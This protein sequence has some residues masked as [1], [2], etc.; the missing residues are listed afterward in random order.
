MPADFDTLVGHGGAIAGSPATV[1]DWVRVTTGDTGANY[2][3]GQFSFGDL[4]QD[5]VTQPFAREVLPTADQ[6]VE[7]SEVER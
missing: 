6:R 4:A 1:R 5:E 3:I 2:F 7:R